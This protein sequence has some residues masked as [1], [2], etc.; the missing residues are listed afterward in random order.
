MSTEVFNKSIDFTLQFEGGFVNDPSD[1]GGATNLGWTLGTAQG[2]QDLDIFD[3]DHDGDIDLT[4]IK[5]M[6]EDTAEKGYYK[7]FWEPLRCD[8]MPAKVAFLVNDMGINHGIKRA[9][10]LLIRA[11]NK[12][13][14]NSFSE[15]G[16]ID[17]KILHTIETLDLDSLLEEMLQVRIDFYNA[18]VSRRPE[19]KKFIKG[20]MARVAKCKQALDT[21]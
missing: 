5:K 13:S 12:V 14:S 10:I 20:W 11:I 16:E 4:D 19:S 9:Q 7:Y 6:G 15:S 3:V 8:M 18:I 2:T 17:H 21:F 1:P